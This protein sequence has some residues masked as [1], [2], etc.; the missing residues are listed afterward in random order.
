MTKY[1][2]TSLIKERIKENALNYLKEKQKKKGSKIEYKNLDMA[3]YLQPN[4]EIYD[5]EKEKL[6]EIRK[7][8]TNVPSNYGEENECI[9]GK[10]RNN[11]THI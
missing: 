10:K 5:R 2:F 1:R 9:C 3:E 7:E 8:M 6:F 11:G 4:C